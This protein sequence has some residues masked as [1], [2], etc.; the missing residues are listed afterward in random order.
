LDDVFAR[1]ETEYPPMMWTGAELGGI[2]VDRLK[3]LLRLEHGL[4]SSEVKIRT[5]QSIHG[6]VEAQQKAGNPVLAAQLEA[7]LK[8][9]SADAAGATAW[10]EC[11]SLVLAAYNGNVP[12]AFQGELVQADN[13]ITSDR[14]IPAGPD[15][16]DSELAGEI[17]L[18]DHAAAGQFTAV[19]IDV[20]EEETAAAPD[21]FTVDYAR[22]VDL[23]FDQIVELREE[24]EPGKLFET[25]FR[26]LGSSAQ[27]VDSWAELSAES[28]N[29]AHRLHS[30]GRV[31]T[32]LPYREQA[33]SSKVR[34]YLVTNYDESEVARQLMAF[35]SPDPMS[36]AQI[37]ACD[38]SL[39]KEF[40]SD[41]DL[42]TEQRVTS[43][44]FKRPDFRII[45][46]MGE[47]DLE[48]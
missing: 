4:A 34:K 18:Y 30:V 23:S 33:M 28:R 16:G 11:W 45:R 1:I 12:I 36:G 26:S 13:G 32:A 8:P 2:F 44:L 35:S 10:E 42:G 22:L 41:L 20:E 27:L 21:P 37:V 47:R 15:S 46:T 6:W 25:R 39:L 14:Y 24:C 7:E 43:W 31:L 38:L 48:V 3:E 5:I 9:G 40:R 29:Y 17:A 19:R